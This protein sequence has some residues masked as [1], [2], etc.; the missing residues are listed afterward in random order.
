MDQTLPNNMPIYKLQKSYSKKETTHKKTL[1]QLKD[2]SWP[3]WSPMLDL[4]LNM[5]PNFSWSR[6][7][8]DSPT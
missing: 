6:S 1:K 7:V 5:R 2:V 3:Q 4:K 8:S